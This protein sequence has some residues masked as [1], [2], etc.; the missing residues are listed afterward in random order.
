MYQRTCDPCI[1]QSYCTYSIANDDDQSQSASV[2]LVTNSVYH[3]VARL[4]QAALNA[5]DEATRRAVL[6]QFQ[7]LNNRLSA[8]TAAKISAIPE[9][10]RPEASRSADAGPRRTAVNTPAA[11]PP[12]LLDLMMLRSK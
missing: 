11:E 8:M 7:D 5:P 9:P 3:G 1:L 10:S 2:S 6:Q 4:N 12:A